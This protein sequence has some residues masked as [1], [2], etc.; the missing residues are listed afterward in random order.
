MFFISLV[1][2]TVVSGCVRIGL[3]TT[4]LLTTSS[5]NFISATYKYFVI[6]Y[7]LKQLIETTSKPQYKKVFFK[8][9]NSVSNSPLP[10]FNQILSYYSISDNEIESNI[11]DGITD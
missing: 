10:A 2:Y 9:N 3:D 5:S 7:Q 6:K 11:I 4:N 8:F 1:G